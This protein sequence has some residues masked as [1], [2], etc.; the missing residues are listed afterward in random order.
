MRKR[1]RAARIIT[2]LNPPLT[3][4][5]TLRRTQP[6][7]WVSIYFLKATTKT[8]IRNVN[9]AKL[10]IILLEVATVATQAH[11]PNV[12]KKILQEQ[13]RTGERNVIRCPRP[14]RYLEKVNFL[15]I[16]QHYYPA[17]PVWPPPQPISIAVAIALLMRP[18]LRLCR[19]MQ[20]QRTV[21]PTEAWTTGFRWAISARS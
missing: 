20:V 12:S 21:I 11:Q 15:L 10:S 1:P 2:L 18:R 16:D 7:H 6:T 3:T 5:A 17:R 8:A 13:Q 4:S 19:A 14:S 9:S